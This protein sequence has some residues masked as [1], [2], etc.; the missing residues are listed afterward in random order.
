[1][2]DD[3]NVDNDPVSKWLEKTEKEHPHLL[4]G[5]KAI[6]FRKIVD[7]FRDILAAIVQPDDPNAMTV[8][9]PDCDGRSSYSSSHITST[10]L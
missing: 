9:D 2:E 7:S 3:Q 6:K 10:P 8:V 4:R 5:S 1:M